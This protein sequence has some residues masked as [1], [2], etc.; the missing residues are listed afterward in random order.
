M[1]SCTECRRRKQK[2]NKVFPCKHCIARGVA[3]SCKQSTKAAQHHRRAATNRKHANVEDLLKRALVALRENQSND[4]DDDDDDD[5]DESDAVEQSGLQLQRHDI[6]HAA[7]GTTS[8]L[9][10]PGIDSTSLLNLAQKA[11]VP[12]LITSLPPKHVCTEMI[13][14]LFETGQLATAMPP[15]WFDHNIEVFWRHYEAEQIDD[16]AVQFLPL[17]FVILDRAN[18]CSNQSSYP[19]M[20][21]HAQTSLLLISSS[22]PNICFILAALF[23]SQMVMS[24]RRV[25]DIFDCAAKAVNGAYAMRLHVD[26]GDDAPDANVRRR[27][28]LYVRICDTL[29]ALLFSRPP[30]ISGAFWDTRCPVP[31]YE[32]DDDHQFEYELY[33]LGQQAL[34]LL[35]D[36]R[37]PRY[38]EIRKLDQAMES[39]VKRLLTYE[40][41]DQYHRR[42]QHYA[43]IR[44]S[45]HRKYIFC[46][47]ERYDESRNI[48]ARCALKIVKKEKPSF[49]SASTYMDFNCMMI[50]SMLYTMK[51]QGPE[52]TE[53]ETVLMDYLQKS[54]TKAWETKEC[55]VIREIVSKAR[56]SR[57]HDS[58]PVPFELDDKVLQLWI[59]EMGFSEFSSGMNGLVN[60]QNLDQ[61]M[62]PNGYYGL[63]G[64]EV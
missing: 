11:L 35:F 48:C 43:F 14:N 60:V 27:V 42:I 23:A 10:Y 8:A 54:R 58:K 13:Q 24:E 18:R 53:I 30:L 44:M 21:K 41:T 1:L 12:G 63:P 37:P 56:N 5:G 4:D 46:K 17:L 40:D 22:K 59:D 62:L 33:A 36:K 51:Y 39:C 2:C 47:G 3:D 15:G 29:C 61:M 34:Q 32:G 52:A 57:A 19:D 25:E 6:I 7:G 26:P 64:V 38:D 16:E 31:Y 45:L 20:T 55:E 28:F 9:P 49:K 50:I